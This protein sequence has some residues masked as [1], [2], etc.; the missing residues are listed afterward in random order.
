MNRWTLL[1]LALL[2]LGVILLVPPIR[3]EIM[4]IYRNAVNH[5]PGNLRI[6]ETEWEG[7]VPVDQNTDGSFE[8]F[9]DYASRPADF[10]GLRANM[11]NILSLYERGDNTLTALGN[12]W[13]PASD[14]NGASDYGAKLAKRFGVDPDAP[15]DVPNHLQD[16]M[17]GIVVNEGYFPYSEE[18]YNEA[19]AAAL[20]EKGYS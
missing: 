17:R 20:A 9:Q 14:N 6:S 15:F 7:K 19:E 13:A 12:S 2:G 1:I 10:W 18:L 16:V 11:I 4:A 8:Q 3:K 5:N